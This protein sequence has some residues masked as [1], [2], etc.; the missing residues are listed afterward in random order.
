MA[1]DF[2]DSSRK[3]ITTQTGG[4][5]GE[6][7]ELEVWDAIRSAFADRECIGYWRYPI[8]SKVGDS[9]KEPDILIVDRSLG[10]VVIE[11]KGF[12]INNIVSVNGHRWEFQNVYDYP[13]DNPYQQAECQLRALMGY[14]DQEP[15]LWREVRGRA[16][17]ALPHISKNKWQH[18]G[19]DQRPSCP[20]IIFKGY[21]GKK[22]LLEQIEQ[23]PLAIPGK[24]LNDEQWE[25]LKSII[26]G[27]PIHRKP[28]RVGCAPRNATDERKARSN[29]LNQLR[30]RLYELDLQQESIGKKIPSGPQRIRGIAG[31]G[32]TVLLCQKAAH[33]C[34]AHPDWH[35]AVV[36]FTQSLYDQIIELVDKSI[37][38]FSNGEIQ[39]DQVSSNL[40]ILHGWGRVNRP[41]LYSTIC[42][43]NNERPLT[44]ENISEYSPN[45][46]LGY[47]CS[48]LLER[49]NIK[50]MFDAILID[51]GQDFLVDDELK[52]EGKQPF[53][54]MAYQALKP[55]D[56]AHPEQRRLIWAYDEAQSLDNLKIPQA[57][58][59]FG[60]GLTK[61]VSGQYVGGI[62][63]SE[64]MHRCYRTP[65]PILTAAHAIG[66][67]LLRPDGMLSGFTN[68]KDW[69]SIGYKITEGSFSPP[70]QEI[71]LYRPPE[72]SPNLVP[73]CWDEPVLK[74]ETYDSRQE[75][76]TKLVED[77][78]YNIDHDGL[79]ASREILVVVLG[80]LSD[81]IKLERHVTGFLKNHDINIYIPSYPDRN[82]LKK[83]N[84]WK[85]NKPEKFWFNDAVTVSRIYRAKGNEAEM[86]Y[87]VGFDN[88]AKN[89]SSISL[90]NQLFVA[91]TR[92]RGWAKLSGISDYPMYEEMKQVI[93]SGDT[94]RFTF[95]QPPKRNVD[96]ELRTD[97]ED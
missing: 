21:L 86:V 8:F 50:P 91:L 59:L 89:E 17:V 94:F 51:E 38:R 34:L 41:G 79:N 67:G 35:I 5:S 22:I 54:W 4:D 2:S 7:C 78:R 45:E 37:R 69:E 81:A 18:K 42:G 57:K 31:S 30:N 70:G 64:I 75:E 83:P 49:K 52:F 47:A 43:I 44:V 15:S 14:C 63:K 84:N 56:S 39:Y 77:I 61:L 55:V 9:R 90:R 65:G 26:G 46:K 32:K 71:T 74:F 3:F 33:M 13:Y 36:F 1:T 40:Q 23:A 11:V 60:E 58:E 87:V 93:A 66:M 10:L 82:V 96:E 85:D 48:K 95:K 19:F 88:V 97:G 76:L 53:Y 24:N 68:K 80:D 72:N 73:S 20:P 12:K 29:V 6:S 92:A 25:L 27:N 62:K 28:L 16:I